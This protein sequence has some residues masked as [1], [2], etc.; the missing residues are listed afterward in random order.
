M[1]LVYSQGGRGL[2]HDEACVLVA[3]G[4]C[5]KLKVGDEIIALEE[6]V[7]KASGVLLGDGTNVVHCTVMRL[8]CRFH[9]IISPAETL[10]QNDAPPARRRKPQSSKTQHWVSARL[11]PL[12]YHPGVQ[13]VHCASSV[14]GFLQGGGWVSRQTKHGLSILEELKVTPLAAV[15]CQGAMPY[16]PPESRIMIT[17]NC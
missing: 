14:S 4:V 5:G 16:D 7:D 9:A 12:G 17:L 1:L 10:V 8:Y 6:Q 3:P 15:P 11:K 13:R 2:P